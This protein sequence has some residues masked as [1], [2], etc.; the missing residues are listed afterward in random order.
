MPRR[1][2]EQTGVCQLGFNR[3]RAPAAAAVRM[4]DRCDCAQGSS[5]SGKG[6]SDVA[7]PPSRTPLGGSSLAGDAENDADVRYAMYEFLLPQNLVGR[8]IG[9]RGCFV[10]E[11]RSKTNATVQVKE[12]P[13]LLKQKICVVEGETRR[14][15][16]AGHG[17]RPS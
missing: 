5:D 12:H 6:C 13:K 8:L 11:I 3:Y 1:R 7:S 4:S 16:F 2:A 15:L 9:P 17:R 10:Q 14:Y